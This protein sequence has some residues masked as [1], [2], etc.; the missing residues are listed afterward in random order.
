M[1][2]VQ[3]GH[4]PDSGVVYPTLADAV[5]GV[6]FVDACVRSSRKNAARISLNI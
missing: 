4:A 2:A 1:R 3:A 6:A 5:A